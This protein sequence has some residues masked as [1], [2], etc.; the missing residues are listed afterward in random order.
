MPLPS[1]PMPDIRPVVFVDANGVPIFTLPVSF[2]AVPPTG[3]LSTQV[4][5]TAADGAAAVG[6][7]VQIGGVDASSL[8]QAIFASVAGVVKVSLARSSDGLDMM[9]TYAIGGPSGG[10]VNSAYFGAL[11]HAQVSTAGSEAVRTQNIFK[12]ITATAS[13]DTAVWTPTTGKKFRL[14]AYSIELTAE[15]TLGG[16]A[17]LD[18]TFKDAAS[19]VGIAASF[20]IPALAVTSIGFV[21]TG[22][23]TLGNGILSAAINQV[24]NVNLSAAITAGKLRINVAGTE[25]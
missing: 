14:M 5:G 16:A 20:Y 1:K 12:T 3:T 23:R 19:V 7:P 21:G 6:S 18:I 8:A 17:D 2:T 4:Q 9:T 24:L 22:W 10:A 11:N 13:G 15:A 25:E